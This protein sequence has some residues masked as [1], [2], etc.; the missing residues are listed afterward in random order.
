[1][2]AYI[3]RTM[4]VGAD[5]RFQHRLQQGLAVFCFNNTDEFKSAFLTRTG[6]SAIPAPAKHAD[7]QAFNA[8]TNQLLGLQ[9]EC[10]FLLRDTYEVMSE[11]QRAGGRGFGMVVNRK[12]LCRD[13]DEDDYFTLVQQI[14]DLLP[15][16]SSAEEFL[17]R[18]VARITTLIGDD[19]H[20]H[21]VASEIAH[22]VDTHVQTRSIV[23]VDWGAQF[24]FS[25]FCYAST[26]IL[27]TR[28]LE[29]RLYS[30]TAYPWLPSFFR[31]WFLSDDVRATLQMEHRGRR[32]YSAGVEDRAKGT[33]VGFAI[34]DSLGFPAAG[35]EGRDVSRFLRLPITGFAANGQHPFFSRLS[36]GQFTDNTELLLMS[37][38][39]ASESAGVDIDQF[40]H[41]LADWTRQRLDQPESQ[42][43]P[44]PTA[45]EGGR[46]LL[47]GIIPSK[48]GSATS[49]SCS[50]LYRII[51]VALSRRPF[52]T[53]GARDVAH[54]IDQ[55]CALTHRTRESRLGCQILGRIL[56][57]LLIGCPPE[58]AVSA[59]LLATKN[60][61]HAELHKRIGQALS[62]SRHLSD[63]EARRRMGT[64]SLMRETL[65]LAVLLFLKYGD[66]FRSAVLAA[67][68]SFRA[69][70]EEEKARLME[71]SWVEQLQMARGGNT[72]GIAAIT[73]ALAGC[74]AG[75]RRIPPDLSK[76]EGVAR[77]KAAAV[78]LVHP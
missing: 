24:T 34:G 38:K 6:L 70:S 73:G 27:G 41:S 28:A 40:A 61:R 78:H 22:Y 16:C 13:G 71:Y 53:G 62:E 37:A 55:V 1:M 59:A 77:L 75:A 5:A 66:D 31:A 49:E 9:R 3:R 54:I 33:L 45:M 47:K 42:R 10:I 21:R 50:A 26:K 17:D 46:R 15:S 23:W 7:G 32:A 57:D 63:A 39:V 72:D 56:P 11:Y 4:N 8:F 19:P 64:S 29:Q 35:I 12:F 18:Y 51:P 67:A 60:V 14:Y 65:P 74:F 69:D 58:V 76:V 48:A 36:A 2:T 25:L 30:F 44:G 68:N 43:W 52:V 20:W